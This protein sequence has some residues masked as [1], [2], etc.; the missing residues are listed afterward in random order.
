LYVPYIYIVGDMGDM[1]GYYWSAEYTG[2]K[3][4]KKKEE[5]DD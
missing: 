3:K 1:M 5:K 4:K 2:M